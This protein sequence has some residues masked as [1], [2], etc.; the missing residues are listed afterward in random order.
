MTLNIDRFPGLHHCVKS[1][2]YLN[3]VPQGSSAVRPKGSRRR[4]LLHCHPVW[5]QRPDIFNEV[6]KVLHLETQ[7]PANPPWSEQS[8][9]WFRGKRY[10]PGNFACSVGTAPV[11]F[12]TKP[13]RVPAGH[14]Y[15]IRHI[16]HKT[17]GG[18]GS[19]E[20]ILS[21]AHLHIIAPVTSFPVFL[22]VRFPD[23]SFSRDDLRSF[24]LKVRTRPVACGFRPDGVL[25]LAR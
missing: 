7:Q 25:P 1:L 13:L 19:R 16:H 22:Q 23:A 18:N 12:G 6:L 2:T 14:P 5:R 21:D 9:P 8:D 17:V 11:Q 4:W 10:E 15:G 24:T 3:E 20:A